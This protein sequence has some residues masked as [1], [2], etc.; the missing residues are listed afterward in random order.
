MDEVSTKQRIVYLA[1]A[2]QGFPRRGA[3]TP[4]F[5][6][7]SCNL[8]R[9]LPKTAWK[10]EKL[11]REGGAETFNVLFTQR[12]MSQN[13]LACFDESCVLSYF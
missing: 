6:A 7:K 5:G 11:N 10:L 4:E 8:A 3:T 2:D 1:V 12:G 9:F 13:K